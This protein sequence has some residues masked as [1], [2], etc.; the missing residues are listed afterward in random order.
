MTLIKDKKWL[1]YTIALNDLI[2]G[3]DVIVERFEKSVIPL[4]EIFG[5]NSEQ[6]A[7]N[8][9]SMVIGNAVEPLRLRDI[10]ILLEGFEPD[11]L[12]VDNEGFPHKKA[13][14]IGS[15]NLDH[16]EA[17]PLTPGL[18]QKLLNENLD[19]K[20]LQHILEQSLKVPIIE[21]KNR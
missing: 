2:N 18:M 4:D 13:I 11:F 6:Y 3:Y 8:P 21:N 5:S 16:E 17:I 14:F 10:L 19:S 9:V 12:M 7:P 20:G 15:Y 1:A